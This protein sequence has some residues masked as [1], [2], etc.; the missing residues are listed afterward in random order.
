MRRNLMADPISD[1]FLQGQGVPV[2]PHDIEAELTRLWGPAAER[3]GGPDLEHPTVT[4][5]VLANLVVGSKRADAERIDGT[6]DTVVQ[7]YPSRAIVLRQTDEAGRQVSAEVS[8][9]CHLPAPGM[10]QVCSERI[11]LR[12]GPEGLDLLPG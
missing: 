12:A 1:A 6:L 9:L 3:A 5:V 2:D 8:A 10:P 4:R 11:V 7:R